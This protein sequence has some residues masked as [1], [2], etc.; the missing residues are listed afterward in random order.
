MCVGCLEDK[1]PNFEVGVKCILTV[2]PYL[3]LCYYIMK[4]R[5]K[6]RSLVNVT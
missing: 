2:F 5:C 6:Q 3:L 1:Y 4:T